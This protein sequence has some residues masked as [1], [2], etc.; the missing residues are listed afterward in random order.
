MA[1]TVDLDAI[2][3]M[4]RDD[5]YEHLLNEKGD[6][7]KK[8]YKLF[9][10]RDAAVELDMKP[11]ESMK[12]KRKPMVEWLLA[13]T[14][15]GGSAPAPEETEEKTPKRRGGRRK[16][17]ADSTPEEAPKKKRGGRRRKK[18][19]E[20]PAETPEPP[21]EE[22]PKKKRGGRRR[23]GKS[24]GEPAASAPEGVDLSKLE[25]KLGKL[26]DLI[27]NGGAATDQQ[28]EMLKDALRRIEALEE[29]LLA[30][31]KDVVVVSHLFQT[32]LTE[33][34]FDTEEVEKM[35]KEALQSFEDD[36]SGN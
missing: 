35:V 7:G 36:D 34:D 31:T 25:E 12:L 10:L 3:E 33:T 26:I 6:D 18:D 13:Q 23:S 21:A 30:V 4:S 5:A 29:S 9:D 24:S 19:A 14:H 27:N 11:R 20:P 28:T 1:N 17:T 2:R 16:K 22:E 15:E 32:F 8:L